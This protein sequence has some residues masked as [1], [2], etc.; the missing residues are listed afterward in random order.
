MAQ[1]GCQ[2]TLLLSPALNTILAVSVVREDHSWRVLLQP[3]VRLVN[4]LSQPIICSYKAVLHIEDGMLQ[5]P[6]P[7]Q[8]QG[9]GSVPAQPA[10]GGGSFL[11][12]QLS[13]LASF[14]SQQLPEQHQHLPAGGG[15]AVVP[16]TRQRQQGL[17]GRVTEVW[18]SVRLWLGASDGWSSEVPLDQLAAGVQVGWSLMELVTI[19]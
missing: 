17:V 13:R 7:Q 6:S 10:S 3:A 5:P 14:Q 12:R 4:H 16:L 18:P 11:R 9:K 19:V 15:S 8:E 1:G 2:V